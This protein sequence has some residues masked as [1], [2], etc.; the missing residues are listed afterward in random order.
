MPSQN[1]TV[2]LLWHISTFEFFILTE[3]VSAQKIRRFPIPVRT[4]EY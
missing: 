3:K 4:R 2:L 1:E